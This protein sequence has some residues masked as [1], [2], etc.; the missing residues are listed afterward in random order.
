MTK[1]KEVPVKKT[2]PQPYVFKSFKAEPSLKGHTKGHRVDVLKHHNGKFSWRVVAANGT[3]V[4]VSSEVV[5]YA[6]AKK[7]L[8]ATVNVIGM[9]V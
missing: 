3:V 2:V 9:T 8:T 4:C 6:A 1:K 5:S 7:G